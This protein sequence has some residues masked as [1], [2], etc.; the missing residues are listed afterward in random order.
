MDAGAGATV[1]RHRRRCC[2]SSDA[3]KSQRPTSGIA[4]EWFVRLRGEPKGG[5]GRVLLSVLCIICLYGRCVTFS[6]MGMHSLVVCGEIQIVRR[7]AK[8]PIP[9]P[10]RGIED[11]VLVVPTVVS[12]VHLQLELH[13][14]LV[15]VLSLQ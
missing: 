4:V 15:E 9:K 10:N 14:S 3:I 8:I 2:I 12:T 11:E 5:G 7:T 6:H 13:V 1:R